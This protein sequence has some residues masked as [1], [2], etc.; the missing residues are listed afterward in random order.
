MTTNAR[1]YFDY[2]ATAPLR[3]ASR[4]IMIAALSVVGNP[5]SVHR[6]GRAARAVVEE[7]RAA[8]A[9]LVGGAASNVVF[10]AS[11]TEAANLVLHPS[12]E[13]PGRRGSLRRLIL[14]RGEHPCVLR[15]HR[16]DAEAVRMV[17]LD[18]DGRIDLIALERLIAETSGGAIL[19]LQAANNETGALQ[20]VAE[21]AD[22]VHAAGG[23]VV[24]DAV[25]MAGRMPCYIND[26]GVDFIFLSSHKLG[27]PKGAAAL[28][29]ATRE[30]R[31]LEPILRGGG[32]EKG[33]RAGTED[34]AA[35]AGFGAAAR[36]AEQDLPI[37]AARLEALRDRLANAVRAAAPDAAIF[38][39]AAP[40]LPNTLCFA[41]PGVS[42]ETLV[43]GLD[44]AGFAVSSGAACSSGKVSPSHV[45]AAMG[46]EASLASGA[47]R[48]SI[49]WSSTSEE[50][51]RFGQTFGSVLAPMRRRR[52][53][54]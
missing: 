28:V 25:Q 44:L 33:V 18:R 41:V 9:A 36:A 1:I 20:P 38:A 42:A 46:V 14:A 48:L 15:G 49:G 30:H 47:V 3:P 13:A 37:E 54:A 10:V 4:E 51:A 8:V 45:L 26:L 5:S 11:G 34:V 16:F 32:Q 52:S 7:A 23:L 22:I 12:L 35:I 21:A 17:G 2:N 19:A 53:A 39:E 50:V 6:E 40:R 24:C 43:I 31:V 27:G 29:G